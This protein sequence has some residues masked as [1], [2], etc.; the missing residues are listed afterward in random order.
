[1]GFV[2]KT[3]Q[4]LKILHPTCQGGYSSLVWV[5]LTTLIGVQNPLYPPPIPPVSGFR[6]LSAKSK[7]LAAR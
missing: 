3:L 6:D 5:C 4:F 1:M 7:F 2:T